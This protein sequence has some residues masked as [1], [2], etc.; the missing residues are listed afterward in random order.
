M[1]ENKKYSE[2]KVILSS[3][4]YR[5]LIEE[6]IENKKDYQ[7]V[8]S[9]KWALESKVNSLESTNKNYQKSLQNYKDFI[10]EQNLQNAYK[11]WYLEMQAKEEI[12]QE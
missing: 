4:E 12:E 5:D 9:T 11:C 1:E 2:G 6:S 7:Q 3:K 10:N 8:C